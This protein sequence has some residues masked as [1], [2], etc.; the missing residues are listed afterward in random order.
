MDGK[1]AIDIDDTDLGPFA[2]ADPAWLRARILPALAEYD[3]DP[4]TGVELSE[5]FK[6]VQAALRNRAQ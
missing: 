5:A 3:R 6:R 2:D 1:P 4:S